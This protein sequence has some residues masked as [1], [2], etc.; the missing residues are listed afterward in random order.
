MERTLETLIPFHDVRTEAG[1]LQVSGV[2]STGSDACP[3]AE[4]L[5]ALVDGRLNGEDRAKV[6]RHLAGCHVCREVLAE[7][8]RL[9]EAEPV[10]SG[11]DLP[12]PLLAII[13]SRTGGN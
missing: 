1:I 10:V 11:S 5:A 12:A 9:D 8:V 6:E 7:T 2:P 3:D 13:P 4:E